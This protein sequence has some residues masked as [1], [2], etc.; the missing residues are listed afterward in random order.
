M[1]LSQPGCDVAIHF[2]IILFKITQLLG[3]NI[4]LVYYVP[5]SIKYRCMRYVLLLLSFYTL[6]NIF[7]NVAV[8]YNCIKTEVKHVNPLIAPWWG[9]KVPG[10]HVTSSKV[11][12]G[13]KLPRAQ[14]K[15][16]PDEPDWD[17]THTK[18]II[19]LETLSHLK[20]DH[21]AGEQNQWCFIITDCFFFIA[22]PKMWMYSL[23]ETHIFLRFSFRCSGKMSI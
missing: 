14:G 4:W 5:L 8:L 3:F 13:Q 22:F 19:N 7:R 2:K 1:S 16:G 10:G 18:R 6:L 21:S 17:N 15:P 11:P 20:S 12:A 9:V 23:S